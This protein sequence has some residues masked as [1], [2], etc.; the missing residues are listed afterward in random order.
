MVR[1]QQFDHLVV[2]VGGHDLISAPLERPAQGAGEG[3]VVLDD[4]KLAGVVGHLIPSFQTPYLGARASIGKV[5]RTTA[6]AAPPC[7][8]G[9]FAATTVPPSLRTTFTSR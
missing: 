9:R 1:L 7:P 2:A 5:R 4:Q 6:P 3:L 8:L